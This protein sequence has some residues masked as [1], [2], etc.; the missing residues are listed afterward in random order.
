MVE[1]LVC[2]LLNVLSYFIF[3]QWHTE[4]VGELS[5]P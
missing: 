1:G 2:I 5:D 3:D 4:G